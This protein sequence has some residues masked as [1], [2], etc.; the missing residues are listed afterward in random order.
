MMTGQGEMLVELPNEE[1]DQ[2]DSQN[3]M[4]IGEQAEGVNS[5][6]QRI[7]ILVQY[8]A[9]GNNLKFAS[10]IGTSEANIAVI[11]QVHNLSLSSCLLLR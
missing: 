8:F 11:L 3:I 1:K 10:L 2:G 4:S 9:E 5:I 7:E 6:F